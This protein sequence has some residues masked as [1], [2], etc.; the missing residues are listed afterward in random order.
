M[1]HKRNG[2]ILGKIKKAW[3]IHSVLAKVQVLTISNIYRTSL[4]IFQKYSTQMIAKMK[5]KEELVKL[6][7]RRMKVKAKKMIQRALKVLV[8]EL[9]TKKS[10]QSKQSAV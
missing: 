4:V 9:I 8:S 5:I 6:K 3:C 1:K 10:T 7:Y 2:Q